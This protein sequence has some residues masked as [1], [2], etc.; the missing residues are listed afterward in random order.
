[1]TKQKILYISGSIGL[2]HVS[3]DYAI[4]CSLRKLNP[5]VE[6][7]WIA[8]NPADEYLNNKGEPLHPKS[9]MFSSYSTFAEKAAGKS[10]LNL[11]KYVLYSLVGWIRNVI[12]F[13]KIIRK[14]NYDIVVGNET[15][16]ILIAMILKLIRIKIPFVIIYDFLGMESMTKNPVE[17]GINY[18]LN[19]IWSKDYKIFSN[20][21]RKAIF[22]GQPEDIPNKK[23]GL[24]LPNRREYAKAHYNFIGY[25]VSFNPEISLEKAKI[26]EELGYSADPLIVCSIG[27]TSIGKELLNLCIET[28]PIL[29]KNLPNLHLLIV[30]GPRLSP[31]ELIKQPGIELKGFVPNLYKYFAACDFAI[32]QGGGTTT[33]ELTALDR[34]F[35]YFPIEGHSEQKLVSERLNRYSAGIRM[36]LSTTSSIHLS[37]AVLRN[38]GKSVSYNLTQIN[39]AEKAARIINQLAIK[40]C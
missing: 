36:N 5:N 7:T 24:L 11:V 30:A 15:Y 39:G 2:G 21:N 33:L 22:I 3:N 9:G 26:K 35:A 10:K 29:Q 18:I 8:T 17:R 4:A 28:F 1:M 13:M 37:Q 14:E 32:V 40:N 6:I 19:L 23:F 20:E 12:V 25:I 34:S 16:E 31:Q 38:F 27:G